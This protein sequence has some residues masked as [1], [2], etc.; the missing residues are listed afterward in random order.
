MYT[1]Y[2]YYAVATIVAKHAAKA[3]HVLLGQQLSVHASK[4]KLL[5]TSSSPA[6]QLECH[7][8]MAGFA[9]HQRLDTRRGS[10][11]LIVLHLL[12]GYAFLDNEPMCRSFT[13][14]AILT[15]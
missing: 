6:L 1:S 8:G 10:A 11:T 5:H 9:V 3:I 14:L 12:C 15:W 13:L 7:S 4:V 2:N